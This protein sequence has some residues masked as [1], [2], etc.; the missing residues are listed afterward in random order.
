[1]SQ[2]S[3][4][5]QS[6]LTPYPMRCIMPGFPVHHQLLEPPQTHEYVDNKIK[7]VIPLIAIQKIN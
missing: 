3:S 1:M 2:F 6:C 5:A 4:V 7:N